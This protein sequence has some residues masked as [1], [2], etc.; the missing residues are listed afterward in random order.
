MSLPLISVEVWPFGYAFLARGLLI[1]LRPNTGPAYRAKARLVPE[2]Y[3]PVQDAIESTGAT[4]KT[5]SLACIISTARF[6][7]SPKSRE[8]LKI[9]VEPIT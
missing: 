5:M 6:L 3:S 1:P 7:F 9:G 2:Y 8:V 4:Q